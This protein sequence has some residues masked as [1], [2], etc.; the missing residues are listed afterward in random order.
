MVLAERKPLVSVEVFA[1]EMELLALAAKVSATAAEA[2]VAAAAGTGV[3]ADA[4]ADAD[5]Y[6]VVVVAVA[7]AAAALV[8]GTVEV[9]EAVSAVWRMTGRAGVKSGRFDLVA[10][11][12]SAPRRRSLGVRLG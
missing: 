7:A 11:A 12:H 1:A 5:E 6:A 8:I 9:S 10:V 4:G 2:V 3:G